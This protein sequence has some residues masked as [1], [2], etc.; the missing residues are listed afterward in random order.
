MTESAYTVELRV[1][2]KFVRYRAM[3]NILNYCI[4]VCDAGP[5]H[6]ASQSLLYT[7]TFKMHTYLYS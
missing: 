2:P 7:F 1:L 4:R 5:M 3:S 6:Q